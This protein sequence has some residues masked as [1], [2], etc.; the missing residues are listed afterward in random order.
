LLSASVRSNARHE[1]RIACEGRKD[2]VAR[3]A[4]V[5]ARVTLVHRIG[6]EPLE[7]GALARAHLLARD[8]HV[9][10]RFEPGPGFVEQPRELPLALARLQEFRH[11]R[12]AAGGGKPPAHASRS[13]AT[14]ND[15][16][17]AVSPLTYTTWC[18]SS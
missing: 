11:F 8:R 12:G 4:D 9:V 14:A 1:L 15:S 5:T 7:L 13:T 2:R 3:P 17:N 16:L 6:R 18:A 10:E